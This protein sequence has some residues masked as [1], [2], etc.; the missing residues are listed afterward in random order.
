MSMES[1]ALTRKN[2]SDDIR[3]LAEEHFKH[4]LLE[5]DRDTLQTAASKVG[6][7][8]TIGSIVGLSLGLFLALRIRSSR[9]KMF[10]AFRTAEKPTH[11]RFA[12][13]RE[14]QSLGPSL[15]T[16]NSIYTLILNHT[17]LQRAGLRYFR[18]VYLFDLRTR[19]DCSPMCRSHSR[20]HSSPEAIN[21][22]R[23][24]DL[25]LLQCWRTIPRWR[26]RPAYWKWFSKPNN[27]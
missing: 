14:G 10:N 2:A 18:H 26:N 22:G 16:L 13:G 5:S 15:I 7:H 9:T 19:A 24:G 11:V 21:T 23:R 6:T 27:H 4:D 12:D 20:H 8:A 1:L 25:R 17:A 3:K